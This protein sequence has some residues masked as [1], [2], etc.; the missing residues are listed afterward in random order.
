MEAH[1]VWGFLFW[2]TF[3]VIEIL[4]K[5]LTLEDLVIA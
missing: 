5:A 4:F 3:D 1:K 2:Q